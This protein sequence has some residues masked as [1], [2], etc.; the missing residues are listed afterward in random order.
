MNKEAMND[1]SKV[2]HYY[3]I[4]GYHYNSNENKYY[5]MLYDPFNPNLGQSS[6]GVFQ[7][8]YDQLCNESGVKYPNWTDTVCR[9][10]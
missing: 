6:R 4:F 5:F 2:G 8:T 7:L 1:Y 10:W 9:N 3:I